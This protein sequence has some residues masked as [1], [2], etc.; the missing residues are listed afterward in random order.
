MH[1][2]NT[3]FDSLKWKKRLHKLLPHNNHNQDHK[4]N[5]NVTSA[6]VLAAATEKF[7][8]SKPTVIHSEDL[9]ASQF[10]QLTG[11]HTR[12]STYSMDSLDISSDDDSTKSTQSVNIWDSNFWKD[13]PLSLTRELSEPGG[14]KV[15]SMI[16]KGRFKI[17]WGQDDNEPIVAPETH[18]V[19]W[20][21]KRTCTA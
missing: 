6:T 7:I 18:V 2:I 11:I 19:E 21:R 13:H 9:T 10:A 16:Q 20:K 8:R 4:S 1:I 14:R 15:P 3:P 5:W 12:R 17:V